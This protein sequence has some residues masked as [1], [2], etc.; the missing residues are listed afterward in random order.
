MRGPREGFGTIAITGE[1]SDLVPVLRDEFLRESLD[2]TLGTA[3]GRRV[4]LHDVQDSE[5]TRLAHQDALVMRESA[6]STFSREL[7]AERRK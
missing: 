3:D 6:S 2:H 4:P 5:G 7:N 1:D